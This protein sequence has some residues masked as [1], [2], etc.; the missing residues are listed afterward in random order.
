MKIHLNQIREDGLHVEG[1][2]DAAPY[3]DA[4]GQY[5][6]P[7]GP[8][9]YNLDVGLSGGG[10]F[11]TGSINLDVE[12]ECVKCLEKFQYPMDLDDWAVQLELE[13]GETVDLTP[14]IREDILLNLSLYPHCDWSGDKV[15]P[16]VAFVATNEVEEAP[17]VQNLW[18]ELDKLNVKNEK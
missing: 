9:D 7:A 14:S 16:G 13:G 10:L 5:L 8:L 6:K 1:Q 15:C 11:A 2:E 4:E 12:L 18:G 3:L 17:P